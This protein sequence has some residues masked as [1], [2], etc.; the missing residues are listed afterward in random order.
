MNPRNTF[1]TL[2]T[3]VAFSSSVSHG[4]TITGTVKG[5]D[6]AALAGVFVQAQNQRIN[7][8]FMALSDSQ[9]H[10]RVEKLPPGDY[11]LSTKIAGYRGEPHTG[12]NLTA[13]QNASFDMSL[14]KSPVRW[15]EISI[16]QAGKLWPASPTKDKLFSTCYT[17]H[18]FQTRMA[19][20]QRDAEGWRGRVQYMQDSMKFSLADRHAKATGKSGN[21]HVERCP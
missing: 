4:A 12:V 18:G 7:M 5:P 3:L 2:M 10:Y 20:V 6:G 15:S 19:S 13:D 16:Y 9:G 14:R 17:C 1:L 11:E 8:T 21:C